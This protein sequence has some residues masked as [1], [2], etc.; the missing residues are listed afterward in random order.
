MPVPLIKLFD[1]D[2]FRYVTGLLASSARISYGKSYNNLP[3][4]PYVFACAHAFMYVCYLVSNLTN[5]QIF[6]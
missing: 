3:I 5:I 6:D 4:V 1:L 2:S